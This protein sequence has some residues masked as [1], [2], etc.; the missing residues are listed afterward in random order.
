[1]RKILLIFALMFA[2]L[3]R[4][5]GQTG[6]IGTGTGTN[7]YLPVYSYYGFN[8]SQQIYTA[9]EVTAAIGANNM[10]NT[11][12]FYVNST[13]ATQANY[14]QWVVY[15]GNTTQGNFA[16]T[17]SWIPS[18]SLQQVY[19]GTLPTMT[20]GTWVEIP[21]TSPFIWD[22]TSNIVVAV[23]E[24]SPSYSPNPAQAWGAYNAG[25]NR[26]IL[27]YSD[28]TNPNPTSP[29]TASSRYSDIPRIQL[30]A[31]GVPACTVAVPNNITISNIGAAGANVSWSV[32]SDAS[33]V[34]RYRELPSG[35]WIE[36]NIPAYQSSYN[37]TGLTESTQYE[38]EVASVCGGV[39]SG[40]SAL[41]PFT[42][43]ALTYCTAGPT[44]TTVYEYLSNVT[45]TPAGAP[46]MVSNSSTPPPFYS[47]YTTDP[48]R[49]INLV[50]S[51]VGNTISATKTWPGSTYAAGTRAWI[52][53]NRDGVFDASEIIL[54]SPSNQVAVVTGTFN[55]PPTAYAGTEYLRMRIVLQEGGV[56][57][58]C[59]TF[60]WGEVE[61]Y[62]VKLIDLQ[63]CTV[64][65]PANI[66][67]SNLTVSSAT[68]SWTL[69]LGATYILRYKVA[70]TTVWTTVN[71]TSAPLYLH[72]LTNLSENTTYEFE[73]ATIC[74]GVTSS[75]S[76]T[77][78]FTTPSLTYCTSGPTSTTVYEY[79]SNVTVSPTGMAP[80]VSNSATPP[81]FYTDYSTDPTR[82]ITMIRGTANNSISITRVWP[83]TLYSSISKAWIDYNR[84][85]VFENNEVIINT[86]ANTTS[87]V[88]NTFTIPA[89]GSP[90][91]YSGNLPVKMRV[92]LSETATSPNPC[93][94]FSYGEVED[95]Y[96]KFIDLQ[97]CSTTAPVP[98][99]ASMT[100]NTAYVTWMPTANATYRIRW[101]QGTTGAWLPTTPAPGGYIELPAGQSWYT[102]TDLTEQTAYQVQ[103]QVK[104]GT[105]WGS[106][107]SSV[108]F[109]TPPLTYC[110]MVGSGSNDY[111]SNV[112]VTP[113]GFPVMSNNSL[114]TNY[115]SYP[116]PVIDL[117]IGSSNNKISVSKAW[118]NTTYSD[119]VTAWIDF[120][121]NGTFETSEQILVSPSNTTTP[122]SNTNFTVPAGAYTGPHTTTMRVVLRRSSAPV[123]CS[124]PA[125]GEVEDYAVRLRPCN[126]A[127]P[128]APT[129][130]T[131]THTTATVNWTSATNN[132]NY[133]VQYRPIT[134][135]ASA[136]TSVD[137]SIINGNPP[138]LLTGLLPATQYEVQIA[139]VCATGGT[140]A[141]TPIRT[142]ITRCDPT[143]PTVTV[144]N[145]TS[146]SAVVTWNPIV[147]S[148]SYVLRWKVVGTIPWNTVNATTL[149]QPPANSYT[150]TGLSSY[151][152][153]EVQVANICDGETD[154]NPYS[155][156]Q[157]FTTVR[158]CD[159]APPG[160]TI[161][162]LNPT[163]AVV[164]WDAYTGAD[165]TNNYVLKYRKV[166]LPGW[167]TVNVNTNTYTL[168][169]L[170]ELTK[171]EMQVANVCSGTPANF[172]PPYYFTTP[173]VIYCGMQS[174][175]GTNEYISNVKVTP[176]G[177][178]VMT[179]S[180]LGSTY[181]D[182]TGVIANFIELIQGSH[183]NEIIVDKRLG[184]GAK[185]G[186]AVWIDFDRNGTFDLDER[187]LADGP[188]DNPTASSLFSVPSDA[189]V[190]MTDYKYVVMRV[191]MSKDGIPVNCTSF[192]DGEVEDYTVRISKLPVLTSANPD[193]I[194]IYPNPVKSILNVK[195]ISKKANY[196]IYSAAG[197]LIS[198]GI[199]LNN[200]IDVSRLVNGMYVIDIEDAKGTAQKKFIKE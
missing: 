16:T 87:V 90:Q 140:G 121:R 113:N 22:G 47:N 5:S 57:N 136:W 79:M 193:E 188:N 174:G 35:T 191:A 74:G 17:T 112:T 58:A 89:A 91:M 123:M 86:A 186:V 199:I 176:N 179:N 198:N 163:S 99:I 139:A 94:T 114:Q 77:A 66:A 141:F 119:A 175:N 72:N 1:M 150:I 12:R 4:M 142:F 157:V 19:S 88:S 61:D 177:K 18:S 143:P 54:D 62:N 147:A 73:V 93:G 110:P 48:T 23:D 194:M 167:T 31:T 190:S 76:S 158:N 137:A 160:L 44:S 51:S 101:R 124:D 53:W 105:S 97:P 96:V 161:T 59:G 178:P 41:F 144:T 127:T 166:G 183:G 63:P 195:N 60:T 118:D 152:T 192:S 83:G 13:S 115:I 189:F 146:N 168:T 29:P 126:N 162:Q 21:L 78:T 111:I 103:I 151:V 95:Y 107:G 64:D 148:A 102:I 25:A 100:H 164:V 3:P 180:S 36:Q 37:I 85:G 184:S 185:A 84:N 49:V 131:I 56:P 182:Y 122:V 181:S 196:K 159:I 153:Y 40:W 65:P 9:S 81:P 165:A 42:T 172:T 7:N 8:Y 38:V 109:T 132:L 69:G 34:V 6:Q 26:G 46:P 117:E 15:L 67:V 71:I 134:N 200:K 75:Y 135:P 128:G 104:C 27:Y 156:P 14:N 120:N 108:N 197:Q 130:N 52:D 173:T 43:T 171:Y 187:I 50:R 154:P 92:I 70:G 169:G 82:Q 98:T 45:V 133:I 149:P 33:Y 20:A 138:L 155:N 170:L 129:F 32:T 10:I 125:N 116:T 68:I 24:N 28:G 55:V 2:F 39:Q 30:V 11:I 106:W 80:M 145:V